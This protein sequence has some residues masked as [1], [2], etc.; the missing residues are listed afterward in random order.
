L[1]TL[2]RSSGASTLHDEMATSR[3]RLLAASG[4]IPLGRPHSPPLGLIFAADRPDDPPGGGPRSPAGHPAAR[5]ERHKARRRRWRD[6]DAEPTRPTSVGPGPDG[7]S[8]LQALHGGR[9]LH[10]G[11]KASKFGRRIGSHQRSRRSCA[12]LSPSRSARA[13]SHVSNMS[14]NPADASM[15]RLT[16]PLRGAARQPLPRRSHPCQRARWSS[17]NRPTRSSTARAQAQASG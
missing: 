15:T 1:A 13:A 3:Q 11:H 5:R 12:R 14:S 9:R 4:Q 8:Q 16:T 7:R 2:S 10:R 17:T 6:D